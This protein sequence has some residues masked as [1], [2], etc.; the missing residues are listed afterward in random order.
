[1]MDPT[2]LNNQAAFHIKSAE[3]AEAINLLADALKIM[4]KVIPG[5]ANREAHH[6]ESACLEFLSTE[7]APSFVPDRDYDIVHCENSVFQDPVHVL[8]LDLSIHQETLSFV[9]LYNLALAY[10]LRGLKDRLLRNVHLSTALTLYE[11]AHAM[12]TIDEGMDVSSLHI[13]AI[14]SNLGHVHALLGHERRAN[15]CFQHLLSVIL[16]VVDCGEGTSN[17]L[18]LDGFFCNIMPMIASKVTAAAA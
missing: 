7:G 10:H 9:L 6:T 18:K 13:M 16:Y 15:I 11:H 17:D 14:A 1:M 12:L 2:I 4:K 3:Y 5:S 8:S